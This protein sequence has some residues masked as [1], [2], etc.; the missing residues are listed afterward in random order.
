M[1][2][3]L[4]AA[5]GALALPA[6]ADEPPIT[7]R[8]MGSFHVG[9]REVVISGKPIEQVQRT[10]GGPPAKID[11]NGPQLVEHMYVQ[12][13]L[14][15]N[16]HGAYPL[17]LWHGG[18]L[19]GVTYETTPDGRPGWL[20][21]FIRR[22]WDSYNS[23]AVE[24]GRSG[25]AP[26]DVFVG[27]PVYPSKSD[28]WERFRIGPG[29]GSYDPDPAKRKQLPGNQFPAEGY[30]NFVKQMVPRWL[31]TDDAILAAYIALVDKVCPCVILMHSQAG[32]FGFKA[33]Q[34]RPDKIKA[35][36]AVEPAAVGDPERADALKGIPVLA[37]YGD[38]IP[39]DQRWPTMHATGLAFYQKIEAAGGKVTRIEL[40]EIGIHGNSHMMM[41][42]RNNLEVAGVI[43]KWLAEQP[44]LYR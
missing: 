33:A 41:M 26:P 4:I 16:K 15:S 11:P 1:R 5:L 9:G 3:W 34:A 43:Q 20:N 37:V 40:P 7:L 8:D 42:D 44:G 35:I 21:Y 13:F 31:T 17:L 14:P 19:T 39:Q 29:P 30:D 24:R 6:A 18:G 36:V 28:P 10:P 38:Y 23:D 12:Y 25:F 2:F 27:A 22:G 32:Q